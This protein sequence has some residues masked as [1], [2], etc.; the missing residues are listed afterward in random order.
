MWTVGKTLELMGKVFRTGKAPDMKG[1]V[2]VELLN[3]IKVLRKHE[4]VRLTYREL[5]EAIALQESMW[6]MKTRYDNLYS[7]QK[8]K[9][10]CATT[11]KQSDI[12]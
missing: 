6:K 2:N 5:R 3:L 8:R 7:A 10:G 11:R 1:K 9:A 4:K 12:H